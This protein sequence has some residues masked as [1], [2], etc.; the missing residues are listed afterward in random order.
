MVRIGCV[1]LALLIGAT[2]AG[3]ETKEQWIELGSRIH[4]AFGY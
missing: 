4:G 2:S 1:V 3:A